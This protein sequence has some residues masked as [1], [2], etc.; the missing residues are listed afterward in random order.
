M[1]QWHCIHSVL[2]FRLSRRHSEKGIV[3]SGLA[4]LMTAAGMTH[5]GFYK[6]F[7]SKVMHRMTHLAVI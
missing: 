3:A 2:V 7:E 1:L 6:H 5:G 4:D